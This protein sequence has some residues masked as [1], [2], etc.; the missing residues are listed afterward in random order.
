MA[1]RASS[2]SRV[3][4]YIYVVFVVML[5]KCIVQLLRSWRTSAA[6]WN[7]TECKFVLGQRAVLSCGAAA[8]A[9]ERCAPAEEDTCD[10]A[11]DD[12]DPRCAEDPFLVRDE[13]RHVGEPALVSSG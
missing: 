1:R 3:L 9:A 12:D 8:A 4:I 13:G 7:R 6:A 2:E 10:D 11:K 5:A